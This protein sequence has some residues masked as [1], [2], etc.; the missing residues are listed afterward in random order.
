[1]RCL[2]T[3][4]AGFIGSHLV[5]RLLK[6]GHE[7]RVMD[8]LS[9]GNV[10]NIKHCLDTLEWRHFMPSDIRSYSAC[11]FA[12]Q[13]VDVVFHLAARGSV[14]RSVEDPLGSN[15][16]NVTGTLN[17]LEAARVSGVKRFVYA[18]S[19]S[20]YGHQ[21]EGLPK[22]ENMVPNPTSPYGVSKLAA[23]R[24][25]ASYWHTFAMSTVSLRYFNVY[26]PRQT[27]QGSYA[28]V[29]PRFLTAALRRERLRI[30]GDGHQTRDFTYVGDVV[31][32]TRRAGLSTN[33]E[34]F[35][36]AM[37][38]GVN[39]AVSINEL[40]NKIAELTMGAAFCHEAPRQ[41]DVLHSRADNSRATA[42][43]GYTPKTTIDE[44]LAQVISTYAGTAAKE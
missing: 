4:G 42:M 20:V 7:V 26:G 43:L 1:M 29:I 37:N 35:G 33:E 41:G 36:H 31:E 14:P 6:D 12:V 39:S 15:E 32:A 23:E 27:P 34:M 40:V 2:V 13:G 3:G 9:T 28:A 21:V 5:E 22:A 10:A 18:S 17:M 38:V 44:G 11:C 24:Y 8:D 25:C 30:Y 16:V 19:S